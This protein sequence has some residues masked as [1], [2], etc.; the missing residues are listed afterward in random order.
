MGYDDLALL[1]YGTYGAQNYVY[2]DI[3]L[4]SLASILGCIL[5]HRHVH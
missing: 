4:T 5:H 1:Q 2:H 3:I